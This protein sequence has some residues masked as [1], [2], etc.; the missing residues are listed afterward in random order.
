[1]AWLRYRL[2]T[3]RALN[4]RGRFKKATGARELRSFKHAG[5]QAVI[6]C[7]EKFL[8]VELACAIG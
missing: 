3:Q 8:Y 1:L 5:G 2:S 7:H 4:C 6:Q